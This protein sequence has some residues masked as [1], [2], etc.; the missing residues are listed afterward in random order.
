MFRFKCEHCNEFHDGIPDFGF[1]AP[2]YYHAV[3]AEARCDRCELS[4]DFCRVDGDFFIRG[5]LEIPINGSDETFSYGV[6]IS[7]SQENSLWYRE[8]FHDETLQGRFVGWISNEIPGYADTLT[9]IGAAIPRPEG[10]RPLI[11]LKPTDHP[12]S[13]LQRE[14]LSIEQLVSLCSR[15]L[16]Y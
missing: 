15:L 2:Y 3:P 9:L 4:S 11:E 6:W 5:S 13:D 8:K 7:V 14:G 1:D 10:L 16:H 12:L